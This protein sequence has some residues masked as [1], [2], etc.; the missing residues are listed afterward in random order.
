M[1]LPSATA[2]SAACW[3]AAGGLSPRSSTTSLKPPAV[4]RP[5]TGGA[6]KT[7]TTPSMISFWS[8]SWSFSA[9]SSPWSSC[10]CRWWNSSSITY[11]APKLGALALSRIDWPEIATVCLTPGD[12]RAISSTLRMTAW[13]FSTEVESGSWTLTSR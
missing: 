12:L 5:S 6:P 11:I 4:P 13:V 1:A 7:L 2:F 9:I 3:S 10:F 8:S